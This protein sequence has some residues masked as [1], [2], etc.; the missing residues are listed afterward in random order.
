LILF[1][2]IYQSGCGKHNAGNEPAVDTPDQST[3]ICEILSPVQNDLYHVNDDILFEGTSYGAPVQVIDY[4]WD[5]GDGTSATGQEVHHQYTQEGTYFVILKTSDSLLN[6]AT[7]TL[8]V[9]VEQSILTCKILVPVQNALYYIN[10]DI[11]FKG[12]SSGDLI[13]YLWDFGDGTTAKGQEVHHQYTEE[14]TYVVMM[15]TSDSQLKT[16]TSTLIVTVEKLYSISGSVTDKYG[17][18]VGHASIQLG[19]DKNVFTETDNEGRFVFNGVEK[20]NYV[21]KNNDVMY[22]LSPSE[23]HIKVKDHDISDLSLTAMDSVVLYDVD[24]N[25]PVHVA[26]EKPE[27]GTNIYPRKTPS[28][29]KFGRPHVEEKFGDLDQ[30]PCI[31]G[32]YTMGWPQY[33]QLEFEINKNYN[34]FSRFSKYSLRMDVLIPQLNSIDGHEEFTILIDTPTVNLIDFKPDGSIKF[35]NQNSYNYTIGNYQFNQIIKVKIDFDMTTGMIGVNINDRH[36]YSAASSDLNFSSFRLSMHSSGTGSIAAVDNIKICETTNKKDVNFYIFDGSNFN[37][38]HYPGSDSTTCRGFNDQEDVVG[39]YW[40]DGKKYNFIKDQDGYRTINLNDELNPEL[41]AINNSG[42]LIGSYDVQNSYGFIVNNNNIDYIPNYFTS[43]PL[44]G[45]FIGGINNSNQYV[46]TD[47]CNNIKI[48]QLRS[49]EITYGKYKP[50]NCVNGINTSNNLVGNQIG[51]F[52]YGVIQYNSY[53]YHYDS[54]YFQTIQYPGADYTY[55]SGINDNNLMTGFYFAN[56]VSR[57]FTA[58][59]NG[60]FQGIP[61]QNGYQGFSVGINNIGHV[62]CGFKKISDSIYIE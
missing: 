15:T 3:L 55:V 51:T 27:T 41:I 37:A 6:T 40:L 43:Y 17:Q 46:I 34:I 57:I 14:G 36:L 28:S 11:L 30:Q 58:N 52:D 60:Q 18:R 59:A 8:I 50:F 2:L 62:L 44:I 29:I 35:G 38:I 4:L 19:G 21:I 7:S 49:I 25:G 53:L 20:G 56:G 42:T 26:G 1:V 13:D 10:D 48:N 23:I 12:T 39:Y 9:T 61:Q 5:F 32:G 33:D 22:Y 47:R 31:F 24:F 16:A 54:Q 45:T